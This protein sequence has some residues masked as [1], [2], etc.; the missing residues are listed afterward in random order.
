MMLQG[1]KGLLERPEGVFTA[2]VV[3]FHLERPLKNRKLK[4]EGL[5]QVKCSIQKCLFKGFS[6]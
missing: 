3:V 5:I 2:F 6:M 4:F 1:S